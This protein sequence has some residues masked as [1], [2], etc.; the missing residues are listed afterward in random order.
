MQKRTIRQSEALLATALGF[1]GGSD[2]TL[3]AGTGG[4]LRFAQVSEDQPVTL[5]RCDRTIFQITVGVNLSVQAM[6][7]LEGLTDSSRRSSGAQTSGK[8]VNQF[9]LYPAA[10]RRTVRKASVFPSSPSKSS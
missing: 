10:C 8:R 9:A 6:Y 5:A 4:I 2:A 1:T 7:Q 3:E